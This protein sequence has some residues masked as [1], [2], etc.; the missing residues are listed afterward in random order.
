MKRWLLLSLLITYAVNAQVSQRDLLLGKRSDERLWWN[1]QRYELEVTIHPESKAIEGSNK[2]FFEVLKPNQ[3]TFQIDL[4]SPMVLDSVIDAKGIKRS[5]TRNE[6]A[7][8]VTLDSGLKV[9]E[10]TTITAYFSGIPKEA[11]NAPWDGGVVWTEDSNGDPFIATA[12]QGIGSSIWWPNKDHSY[13]E[14]ENGAQITLIVPEGLTAVSNGRLTAQKVENAK[15]HWT[16]EV[17]SP[18]N[19]YAISFNVANYV[20]F[21]E[22]YKG[23]NGALDLTY[24][25]LPENLEAA[26]KQ[27]QQTPKMLEAFEYW[28]GPYPF[29]QDGFKLV[30]V[31]YLGMEHQSAVTYGN[32]FENG[33]RGTDLSGTGHGLTFDFI[34][35]HEA[36]HEWF[37]NSITA[38]DKADL[39]MQEGFTAYSESLYLDY[40][41]S[42]QSGVEYVIGTRKRIQ[43][44]QPMVG[45]REVNYDAPGD[46]YYKGAN[47]LNMLRTIVDDD[48]RWRSLLRSL[49]AHFYHQVISS[50]TLEK[51]IAKELDLT[52]EPFFDQ[53]LRTAQ[54]PRLVFQR[55]GNRL[56]FRFEESI[57]N[58]QMPVKIYLNGHS[59]WI[60][61]TTEWQSIRYTAAENP[62]VD[63]NFLLR[64]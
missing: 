11:E 61:P 49:S 12:N 64:L 30:E 36:G 26:K 58:F 20:S 48:T 16:W 37:A 22:T 6:L 17:K 53:Y 41:Q 9:G 5:I 21:G 57:E 3:T 23:E 39:W 14:P 8:Y 25:V 47:I 7:H 31:P 44:K 54:L 55:A 4:Q 60:V 56:R 43:N 51:Y 32:G 50:R 15:S 27:F 35:I 33:Y 29:Y 40:H 52:L 46:I 42:K 34:I 24:Y 63:E 45:P 10:Q 28:M 19:N 2:I 59:K 62:I 1:L 18:I 13:D 38:D